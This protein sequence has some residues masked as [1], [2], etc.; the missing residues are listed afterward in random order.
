LPKYG[1]THHDGTS[2]GIQEI[3]DVHMHLNTS[4]VK[5]GP[6]AWSAR[7][8]ATPAPQRAGEQQATPR[9][10]QA[11]L[12]FYVHNEGR[13]ALRPRANEGTRLML[14][15]STAALGPFDLQLQ[16]ATEAR[17][18]W[19]LLPLRGNVHRMHD[20]INA[21][22]QASQ[23]KA[24]GQAV[25]NSAPTWGHVDPKGDSWL[26][27][28][29]G[30][31]P[32]TLDV[33]LAHPAPQGMQ[34]AAAERSSG[35]PDVPAPVSH[36]PALA[37]A[38][39]QFDHDYE[40]AYPLT[41]RQWPA[42]ERDFAR[43]ALSNM[44]GGIGYWYG[45]SRVRDVRI[46]KRHAKELKQQTPPPPGRPAPSP[47]PDTFAY[48]QAPLFSGVPS[49]SFFPRG[50]MW[51]EGFH[52]LLIRPFRPE[53]T[54]QVMAHWLDLMNA[55][56]WI[57]REQILGPEARSRVPDEFVTQPSD[58]ANPP[59]WFLVFEDMLDAIAAGRGDEAQR[60]QDTAFLRDA[61]PR[62]SAWFK[63][64]HGQR[65]VISGSY[66]WRGR[67]RKK[68][69]MNPLTLTSGLDDYPRAT[70]PSKTERHV[71]L[72]CWMAV[73]ARVLARIAQ[74][75]GHPSETYE[76]RSIFFFWLCI[77]T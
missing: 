74:L 8:V 50:F 70:H 31:A 11:V 7:V 5:H 14:T 34:T 23:L 27:R 4:F 63:W 61:Y 45:A 40:A 76:V 62:L 33:G 26:V 29:V 3:Q 6:F 48:F 20:A 59:T 16:V 49:R 2:F 10:K 67:E 37:R 53:I 73:A 65:G 56:G 52:Q 12:Y 75:D 18:D 57:P 25:P 1:W 51:D 55:Q 72:R 9:P 19:A 17:L 36:L 15:G 42:A 54:R 32:L 66:R 58:N 60:E 13:E 44:V 21:L 38:R 22:D 46:A 41:K 69:V 28:I 35:A 43:S 64:F 39:A 68:G 71:D 24:S 77:R 30:S 47:P